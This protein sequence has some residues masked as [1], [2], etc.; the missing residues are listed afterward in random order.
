MKKI[1]FLAAAAVAL[2][3]FKSVE[4]TTWSVDKGHSRFGFVI[5]HLGVNDVEGDFK[6]YDCTITGAKDDFSDATFEVSAEINSINTESEKRDGHLKGADFFDAAQFAKLTFKSK[7]VKADGAN[8]LIING[9]LTLHGVT[10][11]VELHAMIR[12]GTNPMSKKEVLG[13][14]IT[15]TIKRS[16]FKIGEKFPAPMLSDEVQLNAN[17]EFGKK[18]AK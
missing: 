18:E 11:P 15:G 13:F 6:E 2:M 9:D 16:E 14:K 4:S 5:T 7:S 1:A 17:G 10:N 12:K 8:K 3:A